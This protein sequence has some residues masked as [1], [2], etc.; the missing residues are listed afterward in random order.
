MSKHRHTH[1]Y[2]YMYI[3]VHALGNI[4]KSIICLQCTS[5]IKMVLIALIRLITLEE[6]EG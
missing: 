2:I 6:H 1:I 4:V 3:Y 5:K